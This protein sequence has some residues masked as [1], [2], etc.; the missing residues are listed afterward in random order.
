MVLEDKIPDY[1][2]YEK[3]FKRW[4][5]VKKNTTQPAVVDRMIKEKVSTKESGIE[6]QFPINSAGSVK[7]EK[8]C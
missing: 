8:C 7:N 5:I 4:K 6:M 2:Q 3:Y 1:Y